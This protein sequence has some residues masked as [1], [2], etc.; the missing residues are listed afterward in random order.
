MA[1][2]SASE[3]L[4]RPRRAGHG[5]P[6]GDCTVAD[7]PGI[8]PALIDHPRY[9]VLELIGQGG[10]GVVYRAEHRHMERVVALKV[11]R[12]RLMQDPAVAQR[13]HQEVKAAAKLQHANIVTAHDSEQA[14]D[15]VFLVMEFVE[16]TSLADLVYSGPLLP[17][18]AC[19]WIRQAALG[20]Q[21]AF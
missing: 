2:C 12:P 10:M 19:T 14:G 11:I 1:F 20:L 16:G 9:R 4:T 17:A 3:P 6:A 13:F 8:P 5:R 18:E 7:D 15:L 21:H